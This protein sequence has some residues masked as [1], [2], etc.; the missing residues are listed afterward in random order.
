MWREAWTTDL[1][2]PPGGLPAHPAT[3]PPGAVF[4]RAAPQGGGGLV[5]SAVPPLPL[6]SCPHPP[7][8]LLSPR[9]CV[10]PPRQGCALGS[11]PGRCVSP[12]SLGAVRWGRLLGGVCLPFMGGCALG[13]SPG[14]CVSPPR[15]GLCAG[16]ISRV[17]CVPPS[18]GAVPWD[19]LPGGVC[20]PFV[21]GCALGWSPRWHVKNS[22]KSEQWA[23]ESRFCPGPSADTAVLLLNRP[24]L[25]W[26]P[27]PLGDEQL[28]PEPRDLAR[29]GG[30]GAAPR[31][32]TSTWPAGVW[33]CARWP[34]GPPAP[35]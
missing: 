3:P 21:G 25:L 22:D 16:V 12:A 7:R 20:P 14:R 15:G 11:S 23:A 9:R 1:S 10:S 5:A 28:E 24:A 35:S 31:P 30:L 17:A 32:L 18:W 2:G 8:G 34:P 6:G 29:P 27:P 4:P 13:S 19:R 26:A 33:L